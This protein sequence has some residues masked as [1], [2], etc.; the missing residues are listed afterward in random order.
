[1]TGEDRDRFSSQTLVAPERPVVDQPDFP[2][3]AL[4]QALLELGP[5]GRQDRVIADETV[6]RRRYRD[7]HPARV[8]REIARGDP[9][10]AAVLLNGPHRCVQEHRVTTQPVSDAY[11]HLLC[12]WR[13]D[14][15]L[16]RLARPGARRVQEVAAEALDKEEELEQRHTPRVHAED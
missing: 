1:V 7:D 16:F 2:H 12:T 10:A 4:W 13:G 15:K 6:E 14:P 5:V 9:D 11:G 8:D 3:R